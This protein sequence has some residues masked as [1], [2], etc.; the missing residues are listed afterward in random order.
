[1]SPKRKASK[2]PFIIPWYHCE[3]VHFRSPIQLQVHNNPFFKQNNSQLL[4]HQKF[5]DFLYNFH[6]G[7]VETLLKSTSL[8]QNSTSAAVLSSTFFTRVGDSWLAIPE[9]PGKFRVVFGTFDFLV[10]IGLDGL[11]GLLKLP[12]TL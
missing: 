10:A 8:A 9:S 2:R 5:E 12:R 4:L 7:D 6:S 3:L 11:F 1:M